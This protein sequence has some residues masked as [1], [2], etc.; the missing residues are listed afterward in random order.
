MRKLSEIMEFHEYADIFPLI[1]DAD[2]EALADDIKANGLHHHITTLDGKILDGRNRYLACVK[3]G[4]VPVFEEYDGGD[5]I[6]FIVSENINRR[7]LN[8]SQR[9]LVA[10]R[11]SNLSHGGSRKKDQDANLRLEI[12]QDRAAQ[13]LNVGKRS[14]QVAKEIIRK[15]PDSIPEI[16]AGKI[17]LNK[18]KQ[19]IKAKEVVDDE[20]NA[21]TGQPAEPSDSRLV[22]VDHIIELVN[23]M[24]GTIMRRFSRLSKKQHERAVKY[25]IKLLNDEVKNASN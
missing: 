8:E 21:P 4:V 10:A 9:A 6:A 17:T 14:V 22:E 18:V 11:I 19:E 2:L 7:H 5:P 12:S 16:E 24:Y 3:A 23:E 20:K 13:M 1:P 25:L 15:S